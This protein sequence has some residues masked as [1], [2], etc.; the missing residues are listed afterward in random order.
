M[1]SREEA[2][3]LQ[4]YYANQQDDEQIKEALDF[5]Q[6]KKSIVEN[7]QGDGKSNGTYGNLKLLL[8]SIGLAVENK[9]SQVIVANLT[10]QE[11]EVIKEFSKLRYPRTIRGNEDESQCNLQF[12]VTVTNNN[13]PLE[14]LVKPANKGKGMV[15]IKTT[16]NYMNKEKVQSDLRECSFNIVYQQNKDENAIWLFFF[17]FSP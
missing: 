16:T 14:L 1:K 3:S 5:E 8:Q 11:V 2:I 7:L 6:W 15:N 13:E 10:E 9:K 4:K 17:L 12:S